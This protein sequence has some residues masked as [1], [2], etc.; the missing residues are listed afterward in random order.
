VSPPNESPIPDTL[1]MV[2]AL[3]FRP[4]RAVARVDIRLVP[5]GDPSAADAAKAA[6]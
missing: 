4:S 2:A 5:G 3:I 1:A 6:A